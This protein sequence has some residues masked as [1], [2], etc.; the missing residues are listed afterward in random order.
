MHGVN[1]ANSTFQSL[2]E[3]AMLS[4]WFLFTDCLI[5]ILLAVEP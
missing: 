3:V 5:G 4:I 2:D 1:I